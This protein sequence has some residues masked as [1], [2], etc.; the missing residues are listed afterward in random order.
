MNNKQQKQTEK[1][2]TEIFKYN[3]E[4][5]VSEYH[6]MIHAC[7]P[8]DTYEQ[9]LNA[10]VNAYFTLLEGELHGAV[11]V[12]KRYF[13]SDA[14]NQSDMLLALTAIFGAAMPSIVRPTPN[15][16]PACC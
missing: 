6:V 9:Q 5:G 2:S 3:V 16:K 8:E 13:L 14:A 12:F 15:I 7:C 1:T 11:A 10:V 4:N